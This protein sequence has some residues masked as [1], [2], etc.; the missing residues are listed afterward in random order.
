MRDDS[1][2]KEY[3]A[4]VCETDD[5]LLFEKIEKLL[6]FYSAVLWLHSWCHPFAPKQNCKI[7]AL[8]TPKL[9]NLFPRKSNQ[10]TVNSALFHFSTG[11]FPFDLVSADGAGAL[12]QM[13]PC[14]SL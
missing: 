2:S 12:C 5:K 3:I 13:Q 10:F 9:C 14:V 4:T 1:W 8:L 11:D 6:S 7:S